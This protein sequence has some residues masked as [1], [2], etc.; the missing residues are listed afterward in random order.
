MQNSLHRVLNKMPQQK[1][2]KANL[3]I[4]KLSALSELEKLTNEVNKNREDLDDA[5]GEFYAVISSAIQQGNLIDNS[6]S[7]YKN[8]VKELTQFKEDFENRFSEIGVEVD[9]IS[10]SDEYANATAT[11]NTSQDMI[12]ELD[13]ALN[14]HLLVKE[15]F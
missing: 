7:N 1:V 4:V 9:L 11:I 5:I 6:A 3:S 10:A 13:L 14:L 12:D 15:N 8:A 2:G